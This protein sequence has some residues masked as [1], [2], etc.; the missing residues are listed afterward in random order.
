MSLPATIMTKKKPLSIVLLLV[1]LAL[2]IPLVYSVIRSGFQYQYDYDELAQV[3]MVYFV[4]QG[5]KPFVD[6][7]SIYSPIFQWFLLPFFHVLG[8]TFETIALG[9]LLMVV[10]FALRILVSTVVIRRLFGKLESLLFVL[11]LLLDPFT[12]FSAM[13]IRQDNLMMTIYSIGILVFLT[14]VAKKSRGLQ[15]C[16]GFI[17]TL[18]LLTIVKILPSYL[19]FIGIYGM[20]TFFNKKFK[21]LGFFLLGGVATITLFISFFALSNSLSAMVQQMILDPWTHMAAADYPTPVGFLYQPNNSFIYG[22]GGTPLTWVYVWV[23]PMIGFAG[24][25]YVI[26]RILAQGKVDQFDSLKIILAVS[27]IAQWFLLFKLQSVLIQYYLPVSWLFAAFSAVAVIELLR[28]L[29]KHRTLAIGAG[30][31][32]AILILALVKESIQANIARSAMTSM[33]I[34]NYHEKRWQQIPAGSP[35]YPNLLFRPLAFPVMTGYYIGVHNQKLLERYRPIHSYLDEQKAQYLLLTDFIR[36]YLPK[37]TR[38]YI[39]SRY[40]KA[41]GDDELYIRVK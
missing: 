38:D 27:L 32:I 17:I 33:A 23:L 19:I 2:L 21:D 41:P 5:L 24:V 14:G 11:L 35:V 29:K 12:V 31:F 15:F 20:Y 36:T 37:P 26:H 3:Q 13:Q 28:Q 8:F 9:R 18:A 40:S 39:D 1:F 34:V 25:Y 4:A 6:Y 7:Y 22:V 16:A 30:I 10:L